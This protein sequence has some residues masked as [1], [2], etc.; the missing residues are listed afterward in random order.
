MRPPGG[1]IAAGGREV[2][3]GPF[4]RVQR[5]PAGASLP[6]PESQVMD[7]HMN[8][9][10]VFPRLVSSDASPF[11]MSTMREADTMGRVRGIRVLQGRGEGSPDHPRWPP[12][13][14]RLVASSA[15]LMAPPTSFRRT[16]TC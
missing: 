2:T 6:V 11:L 13:P 7:V 5:A 16:P 9:H 1:R 10:N 4:L 3:R 12:R 15:P 14:R 8:V